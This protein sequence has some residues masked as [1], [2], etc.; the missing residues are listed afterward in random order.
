MFK[1][2]YNRKI[3]T[4]IISGF[5]FGAMVLGLVALMG[6]VFIEGINA[7]TNELYKKVMVSVG[8]TEDLQSVFQ[9]ISA[10]TAYLIAVDDAQSI[11][12]YINTISS[13]KAK[14]A[15]LLTK[16][17]K[18][19]NDQQI[20][21]L[22]DE[23]LTADQEAME[24][25][26][27]VIQLAKENKDE[28]ALAMMLQSGT[29]KDLLIT[30]SEIIKKITAKEIEYG[31]MKKVAFDELVRKAY[32]FMSS[33]SAIIMIIA[34]CLGIFISHA[35]TAPLKKAKYMIEEMSMGHLSE[36]LKLKSTDEIGQ[37][38]TVL[39]DFAD[40]LQSTLVMSLKQI[41]MGDV[42]AEIEI[43]DERDE[44]SPMLKTTIENLRK[45]ITEA[46]MLS[47]AAINGQL[48]KRGNADAFQGSYRE[49]IEGV[50]N[51]IDAL[52]EPLKA[53]GDYLDRIGRGE[54]PEKF[55]R[56][57]SGDYVKIKN[58]INACV[59]G[60]G[61]IEE[62]N[63]ILGQMSVNDYSQKMVSDYPGIYGE[64]AASINRLHYNISY[65]IQF[66]NDMANGEMGNHLETFLASGKLSEKDEFI[67]S[68]IK[69]IEN[70]EML[71]MKP[72]QCQ[73]LPLME[74]W[75]IVA[76]RQNSWVRMQKSLKVLMTRW[77]PLR[78]QCRKPL[79]F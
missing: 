61:A 25:L 45:L 5:V 26:D 18:E 12:A 53:F 30:E 43:I 24:K 19:I 62:G 60:L 75:I 77:M 16:Y 67:P 55:S 27:Q 2:F 33:I 65:V 49:I 51:T 39:D 52:V 35:I 15:D 37:M 11:T 58:S 41:S 69:L 48:D 63:R 40:R 14:M 57:V 3:G 79:W 47:Q 46:N 76:M 20:R 28:E 13:N 74:T 73:H 50:N 1:W 10:D 36:R 78:H 54:I 72:E 59:D 42:S 23:L 22:Y 44:V 56:T 7:V 70:I 68:L 9:E 71:W 29:S 38:A 4:K 8:M 31:E 6:I 64:M 34:V 32:L 21:L 66:N 17:E